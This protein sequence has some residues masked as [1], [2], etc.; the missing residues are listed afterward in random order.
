[1]DLGI[2]PAAIAARI[3]GLIG[4]QDRGVIEKTASRLGV[5]VLSLRMSIDEA[6]PTPTFEVLHAMVRVYGV[7]PSW[8]IT[9]QYDAAAHRIAVEAESD[10]THDAVAKLMSRLSNPGTTPPGGTPALSLMQ[11]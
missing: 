2:D 6:E 3:R 1:M 11:P 7:D 5:N 8:L 10:R 9:G 4:G